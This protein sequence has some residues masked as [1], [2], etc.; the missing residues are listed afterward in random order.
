MNKARGGRP[1]RTA[2]KHVVVL[3][4][5]KTASFNMAA[6]PTYCETMEACGHRAEPRDLYRMSFDPVLKA[7]ERPT[8][9]GVA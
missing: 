7:S 4:H 6:A 1:A 5:P 3:C 9:A 8:A 2:P